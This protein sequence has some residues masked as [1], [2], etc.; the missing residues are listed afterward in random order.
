MR[1]FFL[2]WEPN[3]NVFS[4]CHFTH[5]AVLSE[6]AIHVNELA[7]LSHPP[8]Q[9][10]QLI[11][12]IH[13]GQTRFL[14]WRDAMTLPFVGLKRQSSY[15]KP[16]TEWS[17]VTVPNGITI[18]LFQCHLGTG[19]CAGP[20]TVLVPSTHPS[21]PALHVLSTQAGFPR[22]TSAEES[23]HLVQKDTCI[24]GSSCNFGG[25]GHPIPLQNQELHSNEQLKSSSVRSSTE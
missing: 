19:L 20:D 1:A 5:Y 6:H 9:W 22:T 10:C 15:S 21:A 13:T 25:K 14:T 11:N 24:G 3:Q 16:V 12:L 2:R 4:F 17:T 18:N 8:G 23:A 7:W